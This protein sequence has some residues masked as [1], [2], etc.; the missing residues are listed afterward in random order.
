MSEASRFKKFC[1]A[2]L[3]IL[4]T[5]PMVFGIGIVTI[6]VNCFRCCNRVF[7]VKSD[8]IWS[9][10]YEDWFSWNF[11]FQTVRTCFRN[12]FLD[13]L[14][15]LKIGHKAPN[16]DVVTFG[17]IEKKLLDFHKAGRPLVV[18]FGSCT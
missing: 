10:F 18:N 4:K 15:S 13:T 2:F 11:G 1:C 3:A 5:I 6:T 17:N 7:G 8:R 9:I 16:F 12:V 14:C